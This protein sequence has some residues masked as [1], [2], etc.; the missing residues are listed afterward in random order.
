VSTTVEAPTPR[1]KERYEDEIRDR[2]Q[3]RFGLTSPMAVPRLTKITLNMGVGDAKVNSKALDDAV[4]QLA[5][6][7]G[8]RPSITRAKRSIA[9]F[10]IREGMPIGC[11]VTLRGDRMY[12]FLDRLQTIALPRIR[13]FRGINPRSFDGRGNFAVGVREQ[14]IFPEINYDD[15]S[16][17][18][19]LDIA[20]TTTATSD[21][22]ARELLREF[23]MPFAS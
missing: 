12:E 7:A 23:G 1:L 18:R 16:E 11:K 8:Q 21:D 17:V 4:S 10:K 19:G 13:D 14:V 6:I 3:E 22:Q 20:I 2:L 9:G 15:V 5:T